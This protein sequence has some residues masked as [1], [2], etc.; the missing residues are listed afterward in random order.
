MDKSK[1]KATP[2]RGTVTGT[3]TNAVETSANA[4]STPRRAT[5]PQLRFDD[6]PRPSMQR[7]RR[8]LFPAN[9][10][11]GT[12]EQAAAT[13]ANTASPPRRA[14][15]PQPRLNDTPRP[16]MQRTRRELFPANQ[17]SGTKEQA[18]EN[19][20]PSGTKQKAPG[21]KKITK[22]QTTQTPPDKHKSTQT[23][24]DSNHCVQS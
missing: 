15:A 12:K 14:T 6:T 17:Q 16:R 3:P 5:A 10:Q 7:T 8:E 18:T 13:P 20:T 11:S 21:T 1:K 24:G 19:E 23:G 9:Q 22:E 2:A 4:S